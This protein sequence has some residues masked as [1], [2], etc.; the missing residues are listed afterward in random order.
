MKIELQSQYFPVTV[1]S[2][3]KQHFPSSLGQIIMQY[4]QLNCQQ[5]KT[6]AVSS[7]CPAQVVTVLNI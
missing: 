3:V 5:L 1:P 2:I 6:L 4:S 7:S